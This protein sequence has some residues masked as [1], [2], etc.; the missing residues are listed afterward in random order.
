LLKLEELLEG[1]GKELD[2]VPMGRLELA[3]MDGM[4]DEGEEIPVDN[5]IVEFADSPGT[6]LEAVPIGALELAEGLGALEDGAVGNTLVTFSDGVGILL[7][8]DPPISV[9]F[10]VTVE[11]VKD[12]KLSMDGGTVTLV[13]GVGTPLEPVPILVVEFVETIGTV[14]DAVSP[15]DK[16]TLGDPVGP[17]ES[18]TEELNEGDGILLE[19]VPGITEEFVDTRGTVSD[20]V[21]P[22][23][24]GILDPDPTA[25]VEFAVANETL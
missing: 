19:P 11:V 14:D 9:E 21:G 3:V 17:V 2:A 15:V 7:D 10:S 16:G 20:A 24:S 5:G 23:D 18:G 12:A 8:P 13:D 4:L 1:D 25:N 22:V 6:E